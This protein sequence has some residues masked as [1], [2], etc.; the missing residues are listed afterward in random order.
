[1]NTNQNK[2]TAAPARPN[3][4]NGYHLRKKQDQTEDI[5]AGAHRTDQLEALHPGDDP[6]RKNHKNNAGSPPKTHVDKGDLGKAGK[7]NN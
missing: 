3:D 2:K 6:E 7:N 1:M 5:V 4:D